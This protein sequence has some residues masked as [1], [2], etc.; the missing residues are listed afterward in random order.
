MTSPLLYEVFLAYLYFSYFFLFMM[1]KIYRGLF[2]V[3][4]LS[5]LYAISFIG[6]EGIKSAIPNAHSG[7]MIE[8]ASGTIQEVN[9]TIS[10]YA[11]KHQI[12]IHK[13]VFRMG[14]SGETIK[15]IYT[16]D[17]TERSEY[18][19][20]PIKSDVTTYFY[21]YTEMKNQDVLGTYI[22]T[23]APPSEMVADFYE[24]GIKLEI[25]EIKWFY[26]LTAGLL[27]SI[28]QLFLIL[29][30]FVILALLFYK[31]SLRK[32]IGILEM[33]GR[34]W[35]KGSIKDSFIDSAIY[36]FIIVAFS[37]GFPQL[38]FLYLPI[39]F[40]GLL[41]IW[42]L[43]LFTSWVIFSFGTISD[44]IKGRKPY[45]LL[46]RLNILLKIVIFTF[47]TVQAS[48]LSNKV[49]ET[50]ELERQLSQWTSVPDYY[51]LGF[52]RDT[53]LLVDLAKSKEVRQK[54]QVSIN[55]RLLPLLE[56]SEQAGGVFLRDNELGHNSPTLSYIQNDAFWLS[57]HQ[58]IK[59]LAIKDANG[60]SIDALDDSFFYLLI[61]ENKRMY[62]EMII[63]E[64]EAEL[65]FYQNS[66]EYE[67]KAYEG[68]LKILYTQANQ[69]LF[70]YNFQPYE[71][72]FSSNPI[73]VSMSLPLIQPNIEIWLQDI[74]NGTYLF[75]DPQLVQE[76]IEENHMEHDFYGLIA[77]KDSI[78]QALVSVRREY[79]TT[80]SILFL[81]LIGFVFVQIYLSLV[82]VEM[83][84][85]K[86]FLKYITG[87]TLLQRH[88]KYYMKVLG[89]SG[90]VALILSFIHHAWWQILILL[91]LFESCVLLF[92]TYFSEKR[93]RLEVIKYD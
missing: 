15:E 88:H 2:I 80:V 3:T 13:L 26:L 39:F 59:E 61:P 91:L 23:E 57:N 52:S 64:A 86:L 7:I 47:V 44:K 1:K 12:A 38:Q 50:R 28:G 4:V 30:V 84:K 49:M 35:L 48:T 65:D 85:K 79:Y 18:S 70:N 20:T 11:K 17:Q 89:I 72:I 58:A 87:W 43:Q 19:F 29:F 56:Q 74:S 60:Q 21:D 6:N 78:N 51:H 82:Y 5:F 32:K 69:V 16:F 24:Q 14:E 73:I 68:E 25:E 36:T 37:W 45:R 93:K 66:F 90:V 9:Q 46:F 41:I 31:A 34:R 67:T 22:V 55:S 77:V 27:M 81:I 76:F 8:E 10:A 71:K 92:A 62:T 63:P 75:R 54:E 40:W 33:L 83:N 42:V 53:S